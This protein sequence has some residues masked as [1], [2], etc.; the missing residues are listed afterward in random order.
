MDEQC[1]PD[2]KPNIEKLEGPIMMQAARSGFM[3]QYDGLQFRYCHWC[4]QPR[5]SPAKVHSQPTKE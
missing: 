2:W 1:C 5:P 4:G 3:W